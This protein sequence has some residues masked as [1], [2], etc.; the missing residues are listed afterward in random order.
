MTPLHSYLLLFLRG[1]CS[2][3]S[4]GTSKFSFGISTCEEGAAVTGS[5]DV[6]SS[7]PVLPEMLKQLDT[8]VAPV[9][10]LLMLALEQG[11]PCAAGEGVEVVVVV[12][13]VVL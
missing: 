2:D 4:T 13:V 12:V 8:L 10:S 5:D 7:G 6:I 1:L 9:H 3:S 11:A